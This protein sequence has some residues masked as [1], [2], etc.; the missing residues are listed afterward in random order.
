LAKKLLGSL[1]LN[2]IYQRDCL[3]GMAMIP[4]KSVDLIVIDPPYNIGKDKRWDKW[5]TVDDYVAFMGEVFKEC[6]RTLKENGSFYWFHNNFLQVVELQGLISR[7]T[8]FEFKQLLIWDKYNGTPKEHPFKGALWKQV[9][10]GGKRNYSNTKEYCL[11]YT[12]QDETGLKSINKTV[13]AEIR[14]YMRKPVIER[15][16]NFGDIDRYLRSKGLLG[17]NSTMANQFFGDNRQLKVPVKDKWLALK[18]LLGYDK[19]WEEVKEWEA[20]L[21][22]Q[23]ECLRQEYESSRYTFNQPESNLSILPF[24]IPDKK[25]RVGHPTQKATELIEHL[26]KTSSNEGETVLDCFMG[27]GT[28]AVAAARLNRN[29]IGFELESEYVQIANQRLEAIQDELAER[30]LSE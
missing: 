23:Y 6:E 29:F 20:N 21:K 16:F 27:S 8:T 14:D 10:S 3:E 18:D 26:I 11:F 9:N 24:P 22:E 1:E 30:R 7:S 15:G 2:R 28:T 13:Y 5:K 17:D 19:E 25:Q 12:F 4:D